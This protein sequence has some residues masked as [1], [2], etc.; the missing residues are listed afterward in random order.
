MDILRGLGNLKPGPKKN[1]KNHLSF[2]KVISNKF[3][4]KLTKN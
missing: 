3:L 4:I 2:K 1:W